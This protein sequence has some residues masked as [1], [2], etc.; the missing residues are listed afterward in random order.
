L[1]IAFLSS[2]YPKHCNFIYNRNSELR[3][4]TYL[5]Q[6]IYIEKKTICSSGQWPYHLDKHG[7]EGII[8]CRNNLFLQS[9]WCEEN[10]FIPSSDDPEFE[11]IKE[12]VKRFKPEILFIFGA[13]YYNE[14]NRLEKLVKNIP[15]IKKKIC[16]YGAPEGKSNIFNNYD[17]VLTNSL[18]LRDSL[19]NMNI[20]SEQLNHAFEP[21]V[22]NLIKKKPKL[23]KICFLGSLVPGNKWHTER[24]MYLEKLS[25]IIEIDIYSDMQSLGFK[26]R[27]LKKAFILR[28]NTTSYLSRFFPNISKF[29]YYGNPK[30]LPDFGDYGTSSISPRLNSPLFGIDMLQKLSEYTLTFNL[31]V[32]ETGNYACNMRLFE[33]TGVG[34]SLL[35]DC[36]KNSNQL[37]ENNREITNYTS[38]TEAIDKAKYLL[39]NP[40]HTKSIADAGQL[41]TLTEHTTEKQVAQLMYFLNQL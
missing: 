3:H 15:T 31:H 6:Q 32:K 10:D 9:R 34:T 16:W 22:L 4:R 41:R 25:S 39:E 11:I 14:Q 7:Y 36:K 18:T 21:T 8:L 19:R 37:F 29:Q 26:N 20:N 5:E 40:K 35:S 17:L 33:A 30:N 1:K 27:F 28:Q 24:L 2:I 38:I 23:N 13:S 12:Q